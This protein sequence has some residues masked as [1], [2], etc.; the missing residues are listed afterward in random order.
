MRP[1]QKPYGFDPEE[2][3]AGR[4]FLIIQGGSHEPEAIVLELASIC[5]ECFSE[6]DMITSMVDSVLRGV[7]GL[8]MLEPWEEVTDLAT[9]ALMR[10]LK[11]KFHTRFHYGAS[12]VNEVSVL[13]KLARGYFHLGKYEE[14]EKA[15]LR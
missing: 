14:L 13:R 9:N 11:Q 3:Q 7:Y 5:R 8:C 6:G 1:G 10:V 4:R 15:P 2:P 12:Y